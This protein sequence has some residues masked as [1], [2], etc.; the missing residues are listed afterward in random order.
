M[1]L[2]TIH[3]SVIEEQRRIINDFEDSARHEV[4]R[5]SSTD[6]R[7]PELLRD[8]LVYGCDL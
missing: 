5:I 6:G 2:I 8:S 1:I 3:D 4:F 7:K